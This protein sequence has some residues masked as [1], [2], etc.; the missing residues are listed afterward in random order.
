MSISGHVHGS[1]VQER[2]ALAWQRWQ[3]AGVEPAGDGWGWIRW[4]LRCT[5][6]VTVDDGQGHTE[7]VI[8]NGYGHCC[9]WRY[10]CTPLSRQR[11]GGMHLTRTEEM[12]AAP[13][14]SSGPHFMWTPRR[15]RARL[16]PL[17][18]PRPR[19]P[20]PQRPPCQPASHPLWPSAAGRLRF[21]I[22]RMAHVA[23]TAPT[24]RGKGIGVPLLLC[25]ASC[26]GVSPA[27]PRR[28]C[29]ARARTWTIIGVWTSVVTLHGSTLIATTPLFI[30][31]DRVPTH[32]CWRLIGRA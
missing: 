23:L 17:P 22:R 26:L 2:D 5:N 7:L 25:F 3:L 32:T 29:A 13:G 28:G 1:A 24:W 6:M 20:Q 27:R 16:P 12:I 18:R 21:P 4:R 30:S 8:S 19:T 11:P 15:G 9:C 14:C 10:S 31:D